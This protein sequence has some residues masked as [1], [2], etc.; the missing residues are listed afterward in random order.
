MN[1]CAFECSGISFYPKAG[2]K[3]SLVPPQIDVMRQLT[4]K[5]FS[6]NKVSFEEVTDKTQMQHFDGMHL[7]VE[8]TVADTL[9]KPTKKQYVGW[10]IFDEVSS[11]DLVINDIIEMPTQEIA[12][13]D[14]DIQVVLHEDL[15]KD[16]DNKK[17]TI[18]VHLPDNYFKEF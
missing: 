18:T 9:E 1:A 17:E 3:V 16:V 12:I 15:I 11:I 7:I 8:K 5:S 4:V 2:L 6:D 13:C 14:P 10:R